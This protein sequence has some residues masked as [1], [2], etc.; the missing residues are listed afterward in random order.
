[1]IVALTPRQVEYVVNS[2]PPQIRDLV[3]EH[4]ESSRKGSRIAVELPYIAW[5]I[6]KQRLAGRFLS[7]NLA[8]TKTTPFPVMSAMQHIAREQNT[9]ARHPGMRRL[10]MMGVQNVWFPAWTSDDGRYSPEPTDGRFVVLGPVV[11]K[12]ARGGS[13]TVWTETGLYPEGHWLAS[14]EAHTGLLTEHTPR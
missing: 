2:A 7:P 10:A 6:I 11:N 3:T 1:M 5:E 4:S 9:V 13:F 8:R 14:E 12:V